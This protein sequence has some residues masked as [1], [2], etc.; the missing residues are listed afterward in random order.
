MENKYDRVMKQ[1]MA[2]LTSEY[3]NKE[4]IRDLIENMSIER[5]DYPKFLELLLSSVLWG[6]LSALD[7]A[8]IL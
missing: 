2:K 4:S 8:D 7:D 6:Y 3:L 1:R 5:E